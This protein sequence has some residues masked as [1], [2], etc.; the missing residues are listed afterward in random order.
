MV[1]N[2]ALTNLELWKPDGYLTA[3]IGTIIKNLELQRLV[4]SST[5]VNGIT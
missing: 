3:K 1:S 5:L 4:G 2:I